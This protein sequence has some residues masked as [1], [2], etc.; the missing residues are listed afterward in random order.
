MK[1]FFWWLCLSWLRTYQH[2]E[3]SFLWF[4]SA[5]EIYE[6]ELHKEK[7]A[8]CCL[9]RA[10]DVVGVN[11]Y[12]IEKFSGVHKYK[13]L[14]TYVRS[15]VRQFPQNDVFQQKGAPLCMTHDTCSLLERLSPYS[16][17]WRYEL[18]GGSARSHILTLLNF[19]LSGSAKNQFNWIFMPN[20]MQTSKRV[21]KEVRS[22]RQ[23]LLSNN[24]MTN[25]GN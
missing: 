5:R 2:S 25:F 24:G 13:L 23:K 15:Q 22:V 10:N 7:V 6:H 1:S 9:V 14:D 18:A 12:N 19:F 3:R 8:V 21:K 17:F 16:W 20:I 4:R 11:Y